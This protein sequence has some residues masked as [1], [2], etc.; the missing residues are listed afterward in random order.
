MPAKLREVS[1][2]DEEFD[3]YLDGPIT[4][5]F[6]SEDQT[7]LKPREIDV[8]KQDVGYPLASVAAF[9]LACCIAHFLLVTQGFMGKAGIAKAD[10]VADWLREFFAKYS[11]HY[12][13]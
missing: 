1:S 5:N 7:K 11:I 13:E 2:S 12:P 8:P 4:S 10:S 6:L 9:I 3:D